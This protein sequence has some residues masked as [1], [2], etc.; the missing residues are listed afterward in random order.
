MN[1][2]IVSLLTDELQ[3]KIKSY[4]SSIPTPKNDVQN[5]NLIPT[6]KWKFKRFKH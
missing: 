6:I 2:D 4:Q 1:A 5:K 3:F